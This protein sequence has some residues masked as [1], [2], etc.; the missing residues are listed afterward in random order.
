MIKAFPKIFSLGTR[1]TKNI[2]EDEVVVE[3]KV[4]GSQF[5]MGKI[6]DQLICRSKGT[7]Q[8]LDCPDKMF[9]KAIEHA[10]KIKRIIPNNYVFYCE[11]LKSPKHNT[12]SYNRVPK[13]NLILFGIY[14]LEKDDFIY[15]RE[16]L[17]L[18]S[19]NLD[20]ESVPTLF[21]GKIKNE[22]Q[23]KKML[24]TMS[25]L[26]GQKIEGIVIKNYNKDIF[27]GERIIPIL[28][29]KYVSEE[30]KEIHQKNWKRENTHQ[31]RW[32]TY[33][34]QFCTEA[35]WLKAFYYLRDQNELDNSPKDIGKLM[36]RVNQDITEEEKE[37]IKDFLWKQFGKEVLK[38]ATR[39]L[40]EWY[41]DKLMK[42]SFNE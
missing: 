17:S 15:D 42:E 14:N 35:R 26:G 11:Y 25:V 33:K 40:P 32:E 6:N 23:L 39:G 5:S 16:L 13:N 38:T 12:L 9:N 37:N 2:F 21:K 31:G 19:S 28:C 36:K 27:V 34:K 7:I 8:H 29:A 22:S 20:I 18:W 41:K 10:K 3:E 1:Y 24:N 4:D 30:F